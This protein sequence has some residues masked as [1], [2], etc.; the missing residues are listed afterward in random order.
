MSDQEVI[1]KQGLLILEL[2]ARIK[3]LRGALETFTGLPPMTLRANSKSPAA[4]FIVA[5]NQAVL[6]A[7]D[8]LIKE[9]KIENEIKK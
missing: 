7:G 6:Q 9:R 2:T 8:I 4:R 5:F 1:A 3:E